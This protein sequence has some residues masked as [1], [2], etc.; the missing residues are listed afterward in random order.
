MLRFDESVQ[1]RQVVA[2][3][4]G[5]ALSQIRIKSTSNL[6]NP[7]GSIT[8]GSAGSEMNCLVSSGFMLALTLRKPTYFHNKQSRGG[9]LS[10]PPL[11]PLFFI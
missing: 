8:G 1:V 4:L 2:A 11:S 5:V 7:N 3:Q 10:P 6:T 9:S